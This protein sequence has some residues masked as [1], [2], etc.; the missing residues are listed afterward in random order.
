[1]APP[2]IVVTNLVTKF[3][4][5]VVHNNLNLTVAQGEILGV[6]GASGAGKSVLLNTILG[7]LRPASGSIELMGVDVTASTPSVRRIIDRS[8]GV[9]FQGGALFSSLTVCENIQVPLAEVV[10][11]RGPL[12]RQMANLK[13]SLVGLDP[14]TQTKFPAELSGGMTKRAALAR[15]LAIEP[16]IL[17]MDEPTSG[18]DPLS[19]QAFDDLI[20]TLHQ[21][22]N[23][24]A[25]MISHDL[26]TLKALANQIG[27][28]VN[29]KLVVGT[30]SELMNSKNPWIHGYFH[31]IRAQEV[32]NGVV[33][34]VD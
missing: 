16:P 34:G 6:V 15:A 2:A 31:S 13:I 26:D 29:K 8:C 27:V 5:Q 10:G 22:L 18:L 33:K 20:H 14:T 19:A 28:L 30:I 24:T 23:F 9:L 3:G 32:F 25:F 12:A 21:N 7:L 17:F 1:M 4:T 11:I